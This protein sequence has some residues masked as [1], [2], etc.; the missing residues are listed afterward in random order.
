MYSCVPGGMLDA[1]RERIKDVYD[2]VPDEARE[3]LECKNHACFLFYPASRRMDRNYYLSTLTTSHQVVWT[4]P[5][6]I[7]SDKRSANSLLR[8]LPESKAVK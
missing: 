4:M 7:S 8:S 2:S 1:V 5:N 3:V 6:G